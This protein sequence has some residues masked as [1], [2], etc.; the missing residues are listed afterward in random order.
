VDMFEAAG[1]AAEQMETV[2]KRIKADWEKQPLAII[3]G[4]AS[5]ILGGLYAL[6]GHCALGWGAFSCGS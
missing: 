3:I 4:L 6:I 2:W 1:V 5:I